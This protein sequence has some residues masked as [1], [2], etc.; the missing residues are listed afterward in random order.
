MAI[1][2]EEQQ[3]LLT[4]L[5]E[6]RVVFDVFEEQLRK[7]MLD[8]KWEAKTNIRKLVRQARSAGVPMRQIGFALET[9]DHRTL[10]DYEN[11]V[12]RDK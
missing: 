6:A 5:E 2:N 11:D 3:A 12:R 1:L 4:Q 8:R 9:S 10:K 7:E